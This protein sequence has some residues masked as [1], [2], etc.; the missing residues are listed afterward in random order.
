MVGN[1]ATDWSIDVTPAYL[2]SAFNFNLMS[3]DQHKIFEENNCVWYF[4]DFIPHKNAPICETTYAKF[5]QQTSHINWY[6]VYRTF[7]SGGLSASKSNRV[8]TTKVGNEERTYKRGYTQAEY[9]PFVKSIQKQYHQLLG[10]AVSDYMNRPDVR[11]AMHIPDKV[12]TWASCGGIEYHEQT[13]GS[14]WIYRVLQNKYRILF[15][16]GDT[17]GA[18]P[19]YGSRVWINKL[20][21]PIK[22][23][24]QPY[25]DDQQQVAGYKE[26][27]DGMDFVTVHGVG[28]MAPQWKRK[29]V[30]NMITSWLH[31]EKF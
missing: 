19:T 25:F 29:D 4:N 24:Y 3:Y 18:V 28:H 13:E 26:E 10:D 23:T 2:P 31:Q 9:T 27:R 8:G 1:G 14:L 12:Q 16:S 17:D 20:N 6:D 15:Y 11:K 30:T 22:S 21:W 5:E 7:Y